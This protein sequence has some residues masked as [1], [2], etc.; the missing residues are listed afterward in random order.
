MNCTKLLNELMMKNG[1]NVKFNKKY[2]LAVLAAFVIQ[3]MFG[4][5][6]VK[7]MQCER[8]IEQ[9]W[10]NGDYDTP[11]ERRIRFM[12]RT[13]YGTLEHI[14]NNY[15]SELIKPITEF[16]GEHYNWQLDG[17]W[18]SCREAMIQNMSKIDPKFRAND[19]VMKF[20]QDNNCKNIEVFKYNK[21]SSQQSSSNNS[22]SNQSSSSSSSQTNSSS[23]NNQ[24]SSSDDER[25]KK[26]NEVIDQF[27]SADKQ[28][29]YV[30]AFPALQII[31]NSQDNSP[32]VS[33]QAISRLAEYYKFGFGVPKD[34]IKAQALFEK[35][36]KAGHKAAD[37]FICENY[38]NGTGGVTQNHQ[39]ALKY[40]TSAANNGDVTSMGT[41]GYLYYSGTGT[42][43]Q[44]LGNEW[45]CKAALKGEAISIKNAEKLK[46]NCN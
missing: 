22:S 36:S 6:L 10:N 23:S 29:D 37:G 17:K 20:M 4:V 15:Y 45:I 2:F 41:L 38:L 21:G 9:D 13:L 12:N 30:N 26:I 11:N 42:Q 3:I 18:K 39:T 33:A 35:A 7:A 32:S 16:N 1:R 19:C 27:N 40:C 14:K 25:I 43:N 44:Q 8:E 28:K 31:A 24:S 46:L 34:E 5:N